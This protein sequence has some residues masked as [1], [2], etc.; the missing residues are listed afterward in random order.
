MNSIPETIA[1]LAREARSSIELQR[2]AK[3]D[4]YWTLKRY[5]DENNAA[6]AELAIQDLR[7][8]D[9]E[10]RSRFLR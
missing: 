9:D 8:I 3:G 2:S 6:A 10:L 4:Y 5:Y 1:E 7:L